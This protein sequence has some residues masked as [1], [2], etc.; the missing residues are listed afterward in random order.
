V[1]FVIDDDDV[2][3]RRH[4]AE[5]IAH[6]CFVTLCPA[7]INAPFLANL[8]DGLLVQLVPVVD[9]HAAGLALTEL[10]FKARRD[11]LEFAV[12]VARSSGNKNSQSAF[13]GQARR[14]QQKVLRKPLILLIC[15]LL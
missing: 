6:V 15:D 1:R 10:I 12:E 9:E 11:N 7:L 14:D 4:F 13:Y 2:L 8:F 5:H 3:R